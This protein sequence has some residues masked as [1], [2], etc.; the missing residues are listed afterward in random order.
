M[1]LYSRYEEQSERRSCSHPT[2]AQCRSDFSGHRSWAFGDKK[3]KTTLITFQ[4]KWY[5]TGEQFV[6]SLQR[7]QFAF[8]V[9]TCFNVCT[10]SS[11]LIRISNAV[12]EKLNVARANASVYEFLF[13]HSCI[14]IRM[15]N[16]LQDERLRS[17]LF[18]SKSFKINFLGFFFANENPAES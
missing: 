15:W 6:K 7:D 10:F 2:C 12:Y 3:Q 1:I 18:S 13:V 17:N 5:L 14:F 11:T 9:C 4:E 8:H 16:W